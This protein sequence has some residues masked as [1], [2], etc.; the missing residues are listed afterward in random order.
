MNH[1]IKP[2]LQQ[3]FRSHGVWLLIV[4][5]SLAICAT[6]ALK[7]SN[8]QIQQAILL[9][10]AQL[11]GGDLVVT[12]TKPLAND[13]ARQ[14][15]Q[16]KLQQS[17]VTVFS[18]MA[19]TQDQ[20][21]MVTVKAIDQAFPLRSRL[22]IRPAAKQIKTGEVWLSQRAQD[23]LHVKLGDSVFIAD[24]KFKF[25]GLI[26]QD[27]NQ[28]MGFSGFSPTVIIHQQDV[29]RTHAIQVGSRIE[30]RLLLAGQAQAVVDYQHWFNL[31][32]PKATDSQSNAT[33]ADNNLQLRTAKQGNTRLLKPIENLETFL[34]LTNLLT[35]LLCGVAIALS[36]RRYVQ[37]TQDQI[38]LLRCLG[39]SQRQIIG[40]IA[41]LLLIVM[42]IASGIG[43]VLGGLLGMGLLQL[44]Q[45]FVPS[46]NI[47]IELLS[48][49]L[50]PL[51]IGFLTS[52]I[53]LLGFI[54][55]NIYQLLQTP[56]IQVIRQVPTFGRV[57]IWT[58]FTG[59]GSL[60]VFSVLLTHAIQLTLWVLLSVCAV[61]ILMYGILWLVL[62]GIKSSQS[63]L[64]MYVR[65][66]YQTALQ[67][68]ALALGVS[69]MSVLIVL[70]TDLLSRWQQELPADTPNQFIYGLPPM[71]KASFE[72]QLAAY[73]WQSTPLYP[74]VRG[75]LIAHNGQAF[76][77]EQI[78]QNNSLRRELNLTQ[79]NR[80]PADNVI[81]QGAA[82]LVH[83]GDV[84]VEEKTAQSLGIKVG[85]Q[86][87]FALAEGELKTKVVNLRQVEWQ[88]FSPNFF[89][90]FA[91]KTLDENA[92]SYLSS[93][94]VPPQD[95]AKLLQLIQ[96]HNTTVFIDVGMILDQIKHL[97][98][99][100]VQV[101]TLLAILV[102][103]SGILVL[104]ACLNLLMDERKK[105][106]ALLRAFGS[107]QGQ[108]KTM[109][110]REF[111]MIG[112]LSGLVACLFAE[113]IS[114]IASHKLQL[115][116]QLHFGL[117]LSLPI[118]MAA[119]SAVVGRYRLSYLTRI[120]PLKS[121]REQS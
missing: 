90:I 44:M 89:F 77:P 3:S 4:A 28:E 47:Q 8:G 18:S 23:L 118:G 64:A 26:V 86:L 49:I 120:T 12:D 69:L 74:N 25:T 108:I 17:Q 84:S 65:V 119:L 9:Q 5:L 105:E 54:F 52:A 46:L 106:V 97:I 95:K 45:Q 57:Y 39:A 98:N 7:F 61:S 75:R 10:A 81:T 2:L 87:T 70:R 93:F 21:V 22:D 67:M 43:S 113:V 58:F 35:I 112:V 116:M 53:V 78:S 82:P 104:L 111:A 56:P 102:A 100:M 34:Q 15:E 30:Y 51:P 101:V 41:I 83:A 92:G 50:Q 121:L 6:T 14:A 72:Q 66:P 40:A 27:S 85:D 103:V 16:L 48:S 20:F 24:A 99:V 62:R 59:L 80:Y 29:A 11:I 13:Y 117:W 1:L 115:S 36:S 19:H 94:Y 96:Q 37:Q 110:T 55:P 32:N 91:P 73:G 107:S 38:A 79:S 68:T 63:N 33:N 76:T 71:D 88:S 60:I 42:V 114:A 109:L 31:K